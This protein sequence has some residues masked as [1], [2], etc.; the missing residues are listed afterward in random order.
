VLKEECK[1]EV[2]IMIKDL[3]LHTLLG[4]KNGGYP[5]YRNGG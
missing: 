5:K 4:D 2:K 1:R 3:Q